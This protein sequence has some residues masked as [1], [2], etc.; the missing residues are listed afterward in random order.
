M[1]LPMTYRW[2]VG[3]G[4]I[5]TPA[6]AAKSSKSFGRRLLAISQR[7][8]QRFKALRSAWPSDC[9]IASGCHIPCGDAAVLVEGCVDGAIWAPA[10][11]DSASSDCF[12]PQPQFAKASSPVK[13]NTVAHPWRDGINV[14]LIRVTGFQQF[15]AMVES[16]RSIRFTN[17]SATKPR[18]G[19]AES[20]FFKAARYSAPNF[21]C[22]AND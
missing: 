7:T 5:G 2:P 12:L 8:R 14:T 15:T 6:V 18:S 22:S 4:G 20:C 21:L 13:V 17:L 1:S 19:L 10:E 16:L 3:G 9:A 11:V